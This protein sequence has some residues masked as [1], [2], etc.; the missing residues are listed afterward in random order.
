MGHRREAGPRSRL[1][2]PG[3]SF[4]VRGC[5]RRSDPLSE[6]DIRE[7]GATGNSQS[8]PFTSLIFFIRPTRQGLRRLKNFGA[9]ELGSTETDTIAV[10]VNLLRGQ[11]MHLEQQGR[12]A[13]LPPER[14][15]MLAQ[16]NA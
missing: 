15:K 7:L 12:I 5:S 4:L 11:V 2:E 13:L 10:H 8:K 3:S 9:T 14:L 1:P 6:S 16:R